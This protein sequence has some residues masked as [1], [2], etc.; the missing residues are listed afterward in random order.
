MS[1]FN[2]P[3][4]PTRFLV[5]GCGHTG[6]TLISGLLHINGYG[7][8]SVSRLFENLQLNELNREILAGV[9]DA[10][11]RIPAF[12]AKVERRTNG[13]WSLN[14]PRLSQ[15]ATYFYP[16]VEQPVGV[17][18][19]FRDPRT[20]V[21]SLMKEREAHE[22]HLTH[23]E[24]L[25]DSED[26]WL[27]RNRAALQFLSEHD[28]HEVLFVSYDALVDG[29]LDETLC[30]FVGRPL[31]TTFISPA[32]R[33]SQPVSVRSELLDLHS[34]L[35]VR[36]DANQPAIRRTTVPVNTSPRRHQRSGLDA[37]FSRTGS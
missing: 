20:T 37:T 19:N 32:R 31:D 27:G 29:S 4:R 13:R 12:L 21:R 1:G 28:P 22:P 33:R 35:L 23:R 14:Y 8:F 18:F 3:P 26:E 2:R 34:D 16:L 7:S 9:P 10:S 5:I 25:R 24:M 6:T 36:F 17:I 15:T 30:R 11:D